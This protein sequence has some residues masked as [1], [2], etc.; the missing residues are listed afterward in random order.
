MKTKRNQLNNETLET[1][2]DLNEYAS[3]YH[4]LTELDQNRLVE[5]LT[6]Q[7]TNAQWS[8]KYELKDRTAGYA[9]TILR[10]GL[11]ERWK[12]L[13]GQQRSVFFSEYFDDETA[14]TMFELED[15]SPGTF[16]RTFV[17]TSVATFDEFQRYYKQTFTMDDWTITEDI[18]RTLHRLFVHHGSQDVW[19]RDSSAKT[20]GCSGK[21][22]Q[23]VTQTA[24]V[25]ADTYGVERTLTVIERMIEEEPISPR[26]FIRVVQSDIDV[27][28][29]PL[30]WAAHLAQTETSV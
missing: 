9:E 16:I 3:R 29:I 30:S 1:D 12:K 22:D 10:L 11:F 17:T 23:L 28:K 13:T 15:L 26:D 5:K 20:R 4:D 8:L 7:I 14:L 24:L 19:D 21:V 25:L 27:T 18:R 2:S 6:R